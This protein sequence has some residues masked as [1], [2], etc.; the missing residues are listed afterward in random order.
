VKILHHPRWFRAVAGERSKLIAE[1]RQSEELS[2]KRAATSAGETPSCR[3]GP[4]WA[5]RV[6]AAGDHQDVSRRCGGSARR[7]RRADSAR[8]VPRCSEPLAW[9][10]RRPQNLSGN[11][12]VHSVRVGGTLSLN[13]S[14]S[15]AG[16]WRAQEP[17]PRSHLDESRRYRPAGRT[18]ERALAHHA[19]GE[20]RGSTRL[21]ARSTSRWALGQRSPQ[22]GR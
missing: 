16:P 14:G 11:E 2:W 19:E 12:G 20:I 7:C 9:A 15:D 6:I 18:R 10:K 13:L 8:D 4:C 22:E 1:S 21:E 17:R 3:P 5:C